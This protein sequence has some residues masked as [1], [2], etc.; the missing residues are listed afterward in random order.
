MRY[1]TADLGVHCPLFF[2]Q[3]RLFL[4]SVHPF[5]TTAIGSLTEWPWIDHKG[6][7]KSTSEENSL[8]KATFA[9]DPHFAEACLKQQSTKE[10]A[11]CNP[12]PLI[13]ICGNSLLNHGSNGV[14]NI[15]GMGLMLEWPN[16]WKNTM[17]PW[18]LVSFLFGSQPAT[19]CS[20][21]PVAHI[22]LT[23][24]QASDTY[25]LKICTCIVHQSW[26]S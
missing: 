3:V 12:I 24:C 15:R 17:N 23:F 13:L 18:S 5:G 4:D 25:K 9:K 20:L 19:V 16:L 2:Q 10:F 7:P 8:Y 22:V 1:S 26:Q 6:K 11:S 14:F 21:H